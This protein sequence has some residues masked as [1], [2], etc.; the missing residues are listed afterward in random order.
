MFFSGE[1][2]EALRGP[3][4]EMCILDELARM[5]YQQNVFDMTMMGLRL[6]QLPRMLIATTPRPTPLMKRLIEMDGVT[7]THRL[8]LGQSPATC[9]R[10][11]CEKI[12][13]LYEGTRLGRQE[14]EGTLLLDP[15]ERAV[16]GRL[17]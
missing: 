9:R 15:S 12:R 3:Q 13:E 5:Q 7:I 2:S 10:A 6:G 4:C 8:D 11:S 16:Q 14:L 1:E 17:D